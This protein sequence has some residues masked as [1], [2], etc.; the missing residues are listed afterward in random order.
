[1]IACL[2][3]LMILGT[4][5]ALADDGRLIDHG[6]AVPL[7]E[8]RGVVTT[9]TEDGRCLAIACSLDLS[10]S[11]WILVTDIDTGETKQISCPE[12]IANAAPYGSMLAST[13][14]FYTAQGRVLLE[15]DPDS[16]EWT[17]QGTP[18]TKVG[19]YLWMTEAPDGVVWCGG[20]GGAGLTSFNPQTREMTDHGLMDD[21]EQYLS[22][23]AC[24]DDGWVYCGIGTSHGNLVAYNPA[25]GERVGLVPDDMRV[26]TTG[27]VY[28]AVDGKVYGQIA[29]DRKSVV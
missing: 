27:T 5:C 18:S 13:G 8:C 15:F 12:G 1:M 7:A 3:G 29:L 26:I 23:V 19:A 10:P 22:R 25:G 24:G 21:K 14:K 28:R 4:V 9:Q 6:V 2:L 16:S 17:F 11:G 20:Y